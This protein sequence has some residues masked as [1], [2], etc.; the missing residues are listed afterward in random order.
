MRRI[1]PWRDAQDHADPAV[2]VSFALAGVATQLA[3]KPFSHRPGGRYR[4]TWPITM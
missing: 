3:A 4:S 2:T 1:T